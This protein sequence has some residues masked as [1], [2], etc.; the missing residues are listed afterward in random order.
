MEKNGRIEELIEYIKFCGN[1]LSYV[2]DPHEI[3]NMLDAIWESK[4]ELLSLGYPEDKLE[5][6]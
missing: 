1:A 6:L 4:Q 2:E 3:N 5:D